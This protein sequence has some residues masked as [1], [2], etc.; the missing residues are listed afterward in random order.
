MCCA[1]D[2]YYLK[3][4]RKPCITLR[5]FACSFAACT[6]SWPGLLY[7]TG[8]TGF[9]LTHVCCFVMRF[10]ASEIPPERMN[11]WVVIV[12]LA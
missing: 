6:L 3:R 1:V 12:P 5:M 7:D 9:V 4:F 11:V 10:G 8:A 2:R